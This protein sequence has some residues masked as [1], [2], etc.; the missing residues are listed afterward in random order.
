MTQ[1]FDPADSGATPVA[2]PIAARRDRG[3]RAYLSGAAAEDRV[4]RLYEQ[5][6]ARVLARR[7]RGAGGEIDLILRDDNGLVFV[8]VKAARCFDRALSALS[9]RQIGRICIAAQEFAGS[10][11]DGLLSDMRF[12]LAVVDG[13]GCARILE[14]AFG[15]F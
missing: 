8:E 14:N 4:A 15:G 11:P 13:Q 2:V 9:S 12:D 5:A 3:Q 10:Q 6:G 7:W 1:H